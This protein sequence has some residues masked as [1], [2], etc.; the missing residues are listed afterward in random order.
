MLSDADMRKVYDVYGHEGVE[1][2]RNGG[3][4]PQHHDPFE[5]FSK[6]FGGGGH[7]GGERRGQNVEVKLGISLRDFYNGLT[8]EFQWEKQQICDQCD[9][10][11]ASDRHVDVCGSCGGHGVKIVKHQ[12]APGMFQQVQVAC[13]QCGGRGKTIKHRCPVCG[14][15]RVVRKPTTVQLTVDRGAAQD[16]HVVFENEADAHPDYVAGDL[17]ITLV[18]KEPDLEEDNPD[19]VDGAF[20]RRKGD[21]L[22]WKEALSLREAWMGDWTRNLTHL[23]G[24]I[25]RL[26]RK[27]GEVVQPGHIETVVGEGMPKWA[28]DGDSVYHKTEF[29]NLYV[30]YTVILPDQMEGDMEEEFWAVFQKWRGKYAVD[31]RQ[32]SGRPEKP[33]M[34]EEL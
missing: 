6:F 2:R 27:R 12:L 3:N 33:V 14:G 21:D 7:F 31:L 28:E 32:D 13:D 22:Y 25:V 29:G 18:E 20:F 11:G 1:Q 34:H 17:V 4:R 23:D 5:M 8:T 26:S 16:S 24:H 15:Q 10:T 19:R 9:G 30:D